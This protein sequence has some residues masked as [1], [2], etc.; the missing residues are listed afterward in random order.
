MH[1]ESN[2][3]FENYK[4]VVEQTRET[5]PRIKAFITALQNSK[6]LTP[7]IKSAV[8][9][10]VQAPDFIADMDRANVQTGQASYADEYAKIKAEQDK[11]AA[12]M[13]RQANLPGKPKVQATTMSGKPI[14]EPF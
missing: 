12:E 1:R 5:D 2:S 7:E 14:S 3:I 9:K 13:V 6:L 10:A 11:E 4:L 8:L